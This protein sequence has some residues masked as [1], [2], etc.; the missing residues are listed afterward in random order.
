MEIQ[1]ESSL[2]SSKT[3]YSCVDCIPK[4][5]RKIENYISSLPE[6]S[7]PSLPNSS[8]PEWSLVQQIYV[9]TITVVGLYMLFKIIKQQ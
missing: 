1:T 5:F 3:N 4:E 6:S 2:F 8:P 9:G 7:T